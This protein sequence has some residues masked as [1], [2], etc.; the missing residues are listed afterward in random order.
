MDKR[1][2][3]EGDELT[4]LTNAMREV[5]LALNSDEAYRETGTVRAISY[6]QRV[7]EQRS[8]QD[9]GPVSRRAVNPDE[10]PGN[11]RR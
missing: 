9:E 2:I 8:K 10:M 4:L 5:K 1:Q 6:L 11:E 7:M 3:Q